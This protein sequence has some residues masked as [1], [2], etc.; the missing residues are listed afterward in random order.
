[1][2]LPPDSLVGIDPATGVVC[3]EVPDPPPGLPPVA[4]LEFPPAEARD[5]AARLLEAAAAV[6]EAG[7]AALG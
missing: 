3:I 5:L 7:R 6:E 2:V 4:G 1:M